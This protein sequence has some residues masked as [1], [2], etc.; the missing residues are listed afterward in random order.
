MKSQDY[1]AAFSVAESPQQAYAAITNLRGWW[2]EE[3]VGSTDKLNAEFTYRYKD[4][5]R[6]KLK[7]LEAA[8]GKKVVWQ[9]LDNH[10][11]FTQDK[12]EWTGTRLVFDIARNGDE[13]E[14]RFTHEGLVPDYECFEMCSDA[15]GG[16]IKGSLK[17]LIATGKGEP[18]PKE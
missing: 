9:V 14:V 6:C 2:S 12:T 11:S 8:P 4:V 15:W 3:I 1:T 13:T 17:S 7:L 16:F 5:H 10:F 18:N